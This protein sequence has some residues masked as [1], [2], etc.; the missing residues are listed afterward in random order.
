MQKQIGSSDDPSDGMEVGTIFAITGPII[1][2]CI[3]IMIIIFVMM[4]YRRKVRNDDTSGLLYNKQG[5]KD[6]IKMVG[7]VAVVY[8][9]NQNEANVSRYQDSTAKEGFGNDP[10]GY[11]TS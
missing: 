11:G 3:G 1:G 4:M 10:F 7:I 2:V 8:T 9:D 5:R 6:D